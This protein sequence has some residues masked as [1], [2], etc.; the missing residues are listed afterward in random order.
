MGAIEVDGGGPVYLGQVDLAD[1]FYTL[2]LPTSLRDLFG[3]PFLK[4]GEANVSSVLGQ[5][6]SPTEIVVPRLRV[7]PMGWS[8]ALGVCQEAHETIVNRIPSIP[9]GR[10]F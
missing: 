10:R 9:R 2:E 5:A 4:A 7:V 3:L 1:A 6:V 8:L